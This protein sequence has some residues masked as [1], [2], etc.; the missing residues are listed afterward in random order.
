[1]IVENVNNGYVKTYSLGIEK[2]YLGNEIIYDN[3]SVTFLFF[4]YP[5]H[6]RVY[7]FSGD[8]A[9]INIPQ[10]KEKVHLLCQYEDKGCYR[11][12]LFL[13]E[14]LEKEKIIYNFPFLFFTQLS[15]FI[16]KKNYKRLLN[17]LYDKYRG[18]YL[19]GL[20]NFN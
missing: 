18:D 6:S 7:I 14:I 1:M 5:K 16:E 19:S 3:N 15:S 11:I 17:N 8:K 2:K 13:D 4:Y 9:L 12:K 20:R 10:V